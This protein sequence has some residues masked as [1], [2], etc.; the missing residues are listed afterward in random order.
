MHTK[1]QHVGFVFIFTMLFVISTSQVYA[2]SEMVDENSILN[3]T[4]HE[5]YENIYAF[6]FKYC[7]TAYNQNALGVIVLSDTEKIPLQIDP[8]I[9]TDECQQY[10][11]QIR[12]FSETSLPHL[13]KKTSSLHFLLDQHFYFI[14]E[15]F[16]CPSNIWK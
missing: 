9:K 1:I 16:Y 5:V 2:V 15:I 8:N 13:H 6:Q 14:L 12:A 7:A 3:E 10:G 11:T 4:S